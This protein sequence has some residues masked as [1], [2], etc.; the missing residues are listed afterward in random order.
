MA[1]EHFLQVERTA[2]VYTYGELTAKTRR[3]WL[4]AHG[5]GQLAGYFIRHFESLDGETDFVIAPE[6]LSRAYHDG[7]YTRVGASWM[8]REMREH[9]IADYLAYLNRAL[10]EF[11]PDDLPGV[12]LIGF[13]FSQGAATISRWAHACPRRLDRLVLWGGAPAEELFEAPGFEKIPILF[14][15]GDKDSYIT[16]AKREKLRGSCSAKGLNFTIVSYKGGHRLDSHLISRL[17]KDF[18][19]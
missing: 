7:T 6:A 14:A 10:R 11:Y 1:G 19:V 4:A 12:R 9:E 3:V 13:G 17:S 5:Y 18:A 15:I 8:T 16:E 2:R